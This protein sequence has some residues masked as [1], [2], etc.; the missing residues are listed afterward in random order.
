MDSMGPACA[1]SPDGSHLAATIDNEA[2]VWDLS[3]RLPPRRIVGIPF[4]TDFWGG[5]EL[6]R[7]NRYFMAWNSMKGAVAFDLER[8]IRC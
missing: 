2:L 6:S 1:F 5:L 4:V 7:D 8:G 3:G